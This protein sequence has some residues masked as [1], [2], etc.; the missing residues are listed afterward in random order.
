[1]EP[2][3]TITK[4]ELLALIMPSEEQ[5]ETFAKDEL[6]LGDSHDTW[7]YYGRLYGA[8]YLRQSITEAIDKIEAKESDMF[9]FAI[10]YHK[11]G[12]YAFKPGAINDPNRDYKIEE[13]YELFLQEKQNKPKI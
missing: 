4:K 13:L 12:V 1:M 2:T 8:K 9:D 5:I 3:I 11:T 6:D 7:K 10:W